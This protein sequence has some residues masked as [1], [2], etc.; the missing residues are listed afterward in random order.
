MKTSL[1][2]AGLTLVVASCNVSSNRIKDFIPGTF[3]RFSH[4]EFGSEYDTLIITQQNR[5]ANEYRI[6]RKWKYE[7]NVDGEQLEPEYKHITTSAIYD[8]DNKLLLENETGDNYS[9]DVKTNCLFKGHTKY[10]KL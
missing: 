9:F 6:I 4:H 8:A 3:I 2:L 7:R 1:F 5:A 10:Q